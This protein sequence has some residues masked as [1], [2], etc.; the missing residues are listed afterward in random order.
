MSSLPLFTALLSQGDICIL[1]SLECWVDD[2]R[3]WEAYVGVVF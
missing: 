1:N 2:V 3:E